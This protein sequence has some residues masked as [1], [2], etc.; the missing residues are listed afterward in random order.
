MNDVDRFLIV[1]LITFL[2]VYNL[3]IPSQTIMKDVRPQSI[4][5]LD[6]M[7]I[8]MGIVLFNHDD[9]SELPPV[10]APERPHDGQIWGELR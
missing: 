8:F 7:G 4:H 3:D 10:L 1:I 9:H 5:L 6:Q 2:A